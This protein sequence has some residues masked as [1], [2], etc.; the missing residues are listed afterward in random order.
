MAA[1]T[2]VSPDRTSR[3]SDGTFGVYY[4]AYGLETALR[5]HT[6]H[7]GRFYQSAN[8]EPGWISEVRQL[9]GS[10]D[11]VLVDLRR[12]DHAD[13]PD[14][15]IATYTGLKQTAEH[16]PKIYQARHLNPAADRLIQLAEKTGDDFELGQVF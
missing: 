8:I 13:L 10:I 16:M 1:F 15:E 7:R 12:S 9:V 5:E 2:H 14:P 4:A 11:A 6:F 3:F